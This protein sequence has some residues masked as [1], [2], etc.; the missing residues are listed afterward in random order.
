MSTAWRDRQ[1]RGSRFAIEV[2]IRLALGCGRTVCRTLLAPPISLYFLATAPEARAASRQFLSR[3]LGREATFRE[4]FAHFR[5]FG[6]IMLDRLYLLTG[7]HDCLSIEVEDERHL[8]EALAK[9][10]G[11]LLFGSHLGSFELMSVLGS[12]HKRLPINV[13]MHVP[14]GTSIHSMI[15]AHG[16][17]VP[18]RI[19]PLGS[20]GAMMQVKEC[21]ERNEV[22]GLLVDRVYGS[23]ATC[24]VPFLGAD[25]RFSLA[26]Y[27]LAGITGAPVVMAYG[28]FLGGN[29]YRVSFTPLAERIERDRGARHDGVQPWVERYVAGLEARAR[30]APRNWF[31][32]YDY[33]A[34]R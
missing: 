8:T 31:N 5:C 28:L 30:E 14:P 7:R 33:W 2:L 24:D 32:F 26:P 18:Y 29:R 1:E 9:G 25:A 3:A 16:G 4:V 10:R 6:T 11:C 12:A 15:S 21:L 34:H 22:V 27:Q 13:V 20:P 23:E 19:I 17:G